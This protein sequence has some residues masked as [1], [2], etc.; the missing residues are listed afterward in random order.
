MQMTS[1]AIAARSPQHFPALF[2]AHG[3]PTMVLQPG[4]A[5]AALTRAAA[6]LPRPRAIVV[7]SAHWQTATA[8][9]WHRTR[10][11]NDPRLLRFSGTAVPCPLPGAVATPVSREQVR[12]LLL[13]DGFEVRR[14]TSSAAWTT[15][16]GRRCSLMY[17]QADIPVL[18]LSLQTALGP[19]H[20]FRV[21]RALAPLLADGVLLLA[22]GNITH[23]LG[24]FR[25]SFAEGSGTPAYVAEFADWIGQRIAA[26][27]R[28]FAARLPPAGA[29]SRPRAPERRASAAATTS[30]SAPPASIT[31][32]KAC[33]RASTSVVL[34]MDSYAFWPTSTPSP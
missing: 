15:A 10:T 14:W 32:R 8:D 4:P 28:R 29:A 7:V 17:P 5:G 24:D 11:R 23:N 31:G 1:P 25:R 2:V 22:S 9:D 34:A 3:A 27:D 6:E 12:T 13:R 21:G 19:K 16:P 20:H 30:P 26:G 33:T 18:P